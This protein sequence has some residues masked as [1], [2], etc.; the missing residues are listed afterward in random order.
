VGRR[1]KHR[2]DDFRHNDGLYCRLPIDARRFGA[3]FKLAESNR[4]AIESD[5]GAPSIADTYGATCAQ[6]PFGISLLRGTGRPAAILRAVVSVV[7][8]AIE[9]MDRRRAQAHV[10]QERHEIMAPAQFAHLSAS[11]AVT[12]SVVMSNPSRLVPRATVRP[13]RADLIVNY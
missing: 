7:V 8:A 3:G 1:A 6:G 11:V 2:A 5:R 9:R 13:A 10:G 12:S 4:A